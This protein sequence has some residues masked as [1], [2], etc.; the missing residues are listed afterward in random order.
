MTP[1]SHHRPVRSDERASAAR[2][3]PGIGSGS[4]VWPSARTAPSWRPGADDRLVMVWDV[5]SGQR[6]AVYDGSRGR[7]ERSR[8]Q[9]RRRRR[10]GP[11]AMTVR[12]SS[13]TC[14][15]RTRSSIG[16]LAWPTGP[17]CRSTP[18]DMVIGPGGRYV[19]FPSADDLPASGSAMSPRAPSAGRRTRRSFIS[20]SPDGKRYLT[21][22]DFGRLRVWDRETGA[23][24]AD[25]KGSGQLFTGLSRRDT[26]VFT[27]DGRHVVALRGSDVERGRS[28]KTSSSCSTPRR[29]HRS[30]ETRCWLGHVRPHAL[31]HARR[32]HERSWSC[33]APDHGGDEGAPRGSRDAS[34]RAFDAGRGARPAPRSA[35]RNNTVAPDGRTVGV[36]GNFGDVVVVDAVTG[37]VSPLLDAH[38]DFVESVTFAPDLATFVTTGQDGAVKLWDTETH[39]RP[40]LRPAVGAEPS[41]PGVVPRRRP[42][43]ARLRH[44]R[45]LRVGSATRRLG[46]ARVPGRRPQFHPVRVGRPVPR[47]AVPEDLPPVPGRDLTLCHRRR[48]TRRE[49]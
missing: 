29:S 34:H 24:L 38:D 17:R 8:L 11:G 15:A 10:C 18:V 19:A 22:D 6:R 47:R 5:A 49:R 35:A 23:V 20:F 14:S 31:C 30:A 1:G 45:D 21:V 9:P 33:R 12:S 37:E 25:S 32:P 41:R 16:H 44:G 48:R 43:A 39:D 46:G 3:W 27:P 36:G 7:C 13:G 42:A 2:F 4:S 26:A 40:R 28:S